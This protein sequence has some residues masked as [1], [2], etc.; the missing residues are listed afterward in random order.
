MGWQG[1]LNIVTG[2]FNAFVT[3]VEAPMNLVKD[4]VNKAIEYIKEKFNFDWKLPKLKMPHF[5][6]EGEW[7]LK[8]LKAPTFSIDWY[9]KAM[10]DPMIMNSPTAFGI[11]SLG[12]IMAGGEA[13]S[14]VV[15]GTDTLMQMIATAVSA[16]N[17][18]IAQSVVE[19][20]NSM[21]EAIREVVE[22]IEDGFEMDYD[23][24]NLGRL[25]RK[26]A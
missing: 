6:I 14:E 10:N 23:D 3:V 15:S 4:I 8:Q 5:T 25:V 17:G 26:H 18:T 12:Q 20:L 13:G 22:I 7:N 19:K 24:R 16:G 11:N 1:I 21:E 9:A 2:I